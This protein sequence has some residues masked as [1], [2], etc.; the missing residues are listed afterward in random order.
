MFQ[1]SKCSS[2]ARLVHAVLWYVHILPST[3]T[4]T[5]MHEKKYNKT[6]RTS[7]PEDGHLSV[8]NMSKSR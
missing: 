2:S 3:R 6:A 7:L 1:T 5:W 4:L 8:R